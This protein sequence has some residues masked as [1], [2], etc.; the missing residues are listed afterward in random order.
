MC[1]RTEAARVVVLQLQMILAT[2]Y[3]ESIA[4][5]GDQVQELLSKLLS[6]GLPGLLLVFQGSHRHNLQTEQGLPVRSHVLCRESVIKS[7]FLQ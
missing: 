2:L 7:L 5:E 1:C 6:Y 4:T 3:K